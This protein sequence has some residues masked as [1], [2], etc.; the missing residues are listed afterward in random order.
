MKLKIF[1]QEEADQEKEVYLRLIDEY[2]EIKLVETN[3]QGNI[4]PSGYICK[5]TP[6]GIDICRGYKGSL[7]TT[8]LKRVVVSNN[9]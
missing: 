8:D 3:K 9:R 4:K 1:N 7:A 6:Q 5:I 2:G